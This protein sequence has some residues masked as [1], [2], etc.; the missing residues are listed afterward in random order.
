MFVR[1][2]CFNRH[3]TDARHAANVCGKTMRAAYNGGCPAIFV[4]TN[5]CQNK[6]FKINANQKTYTMKEDAK[7][8][9][10]TKVLMAAYFK[11]LPA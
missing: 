4:S 6:T 1:G 2:G 10:I 11:I 7:N 5:Q 3:Y 9:V 8:K